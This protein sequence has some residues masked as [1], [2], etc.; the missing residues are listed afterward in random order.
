MLCRYFY[1]QH[2]GQDTPLAVTVPMQQQLPRLDTDRHEGQP[3]TL[4]EQGGAQGQ[5]MH[6]IITKVATL[7]GEMLIC[8]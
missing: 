1:F 7:N 3:L 5:V 8:Y 4:A 2:L 6:T